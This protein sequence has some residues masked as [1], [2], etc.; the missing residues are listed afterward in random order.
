VID[1]AR[2][3]RQM[4]VAEIG[5]AGQARLLA[6]TARVAGD[7]LHHEIATAYASRAGIG[8]VLAGPIDDALAPS[9]VSTPAARAVIAGSRAA[10]AS[11]RAALGAMPEEKNRKGAKDANNSGIRS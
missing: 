9:F 11:I 2:Y 7:G 8:T 6:A 5:E 1:R 10:L 4:L 3:A